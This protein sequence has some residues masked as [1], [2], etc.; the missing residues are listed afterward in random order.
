[1][2]VGRV[3][4]FW[5]G[6]GEI[7]IMFTMGLGL[8]LVGA[9]LYRAGLF[10][11]E[12]GQ[13]RRRVM[14]AAFGLG[15]PIDATAR[16]FFHDTL[17][18]Y[19]RYFTSA[20]VSFGLLAAIAA[21]YAHGRQPRWLG[22]P[23]QLVGRMALTCYILQNL[24]CSLIFYDFGLGLANRVPPEYSTVATMIVYVIV[25]AMLVTLSWAWL[26]RWPRG[27]VELVWHWSYEAIMRRV[28]KRPSVRTATP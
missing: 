1:M 15:F 27:P 13:L 3:S 18:A 2:V 23:F 9:H 22:R 21:F 20:L 17:S 24:I 10:R 28:R 12:G 26:R 11:P 19:T 7:P 16:L 25:C 8:F 6:R 5:G 4:E 14:I